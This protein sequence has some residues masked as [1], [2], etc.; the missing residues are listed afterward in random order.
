MRWSSGARTEKIAK[1]VAEDFTLKTEG[2][3]SVCGQENST[4]A[5]GQRCA[6]NRIAFQQSLTSQGPRW[7]LC[8]FF[9]ASRVSIRAKEVL[10]SFS[11]AR[12]FHRELKHLQFKT[13]TRR[14]TS[15]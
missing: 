9:I 7:G 1:S 14:R 4:R 15:G 3:Q 2:T 5:S 11:S 8:F 10:D 6:A 12:Y 13:E